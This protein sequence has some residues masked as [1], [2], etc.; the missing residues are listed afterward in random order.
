VLG[1]QAHAPAAPAGR[2]LC[3]LGREQL[4]PTLALLV[5]PAVRDALGRA[6]DDVDAPLQ[7]RVEGGIGH[8][9]LELD[10]RLVLLGV[11]RLLE[12]GHAHLLAPVEPLHLQGA[13]RCAG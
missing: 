4:D 8:R 6:L 11:V 13:R 9:S 5:C 1:A 10:Q 3:G 12:Q 7:A 2:V